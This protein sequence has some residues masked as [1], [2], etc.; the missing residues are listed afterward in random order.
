MALASGN[1]RSLISANWGQ[2][3]PLVV[4]SILG[5]L[6]KPTREMLL[7]LINYLLGLG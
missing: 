3:L 1:Q 4:W 2:Q 5:V 6:Q 7:E